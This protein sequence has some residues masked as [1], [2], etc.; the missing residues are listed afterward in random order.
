MTPQSST[1]EQIEEQIKKLKAQLPKSPRKPKK[2]PVALSYEE[3]IQLIK[4]TNKKHHKFAFLLGFESGLRISEILNLEPRDIDIKE[5]KILVRQGKGKKDRIVGLPKHFREEYLRLL[6]I[7]CG[8]RS[9]EKA[10]KGAARR[11]SLLEKK[12]TL[13][14]HSLRHGF[15]SHLAN[16]NVPIHHIRTLMGHSNI[17]TTNVYL[18][19][20][21]TQALKSVE[22]LF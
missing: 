16:Q 11:A 6:P 7:K 17:S 15:G 20:N 5:K 1:K 3:F 14:F 10:F 19:M 21:P 18:E 4:S 2:L 8:E 12:P 9:L 13:H 22:E